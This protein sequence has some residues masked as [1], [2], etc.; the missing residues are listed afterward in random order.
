MRISP[1]HLF[2][3]GPHRLSLFLALGLLMSSMP[4]GGAASAASSTESKREAS[5]LLGML[6]MKFLPLP[7]AT[8]TQ[9]AFSISPSSGVQGKEYEVIVSSKDDCL[10]NPLKTFKLY[11]PIGSGIVVNS[12]Q[13]DCQLTAKLTIAP[14][15]PLGPVKLWLTKDAGQ[16]NTPTVEFTV[17][18][19]TPQPIP[20]GL[21]NKGT[22][23]VMWSVLPDAVTNDNFGGKVSREFYCIEAVIGNDSGYDLQLSSIGFTLPGLA[24]GKY[25]IPSSGYRTV[26]GSLEAFQT[27]APRQFVVN[28]FK[29]LG[30]LLTGFLPFFHAVNHKSNF[31]QAI[32]V[33]SNPLEKG[34]ESIWPDLVPTELDRLAD[35][36]FRDDVS[37]KTIIPNN[38]QARIL[39]FVPRRLVCP[40]KKTCSAANSTPTLSAKNPQHVMQALGEIVIVGQ[41][42][43]HVNRVRV[44]NTP[45]G[46][47]VTDHSISGKITDACNEGVGDVTVSLSAGGGFLDRTVTTAKDGTYEFANIPDGRT[48]T[49]KPELGDMKFLPAISESFLLN[50]TKTNLDFSAGHLIVGTAK[51]G[52]TPLKQYSIELTQ[53]VATAKKTMTTSTN[54]KG[55]YRFQLPGAATP[56]FTIKPVDLKDHTFKPVKVDW[57]CGMGPVDFVATPTPSPSPAASAPQ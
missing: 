22:V 17:T 38:V 30:P 27:L 47:S 16:L 4:T 6:P 56:P 7:D 50:D 15:A 54:D 41:E 28:G 35:M 49:V 14:D 36:T 53:I 12:K 48:Y 26:R 8:P 55:E 18:G 25:R 51:K 2:Q 13:G 57:N 23:D 9:P 45:F 21:N 32:N 24:A 3:R 11:A 34:L 42:I 40:D 52:E 43:V 1:S 33:I 46:T 10:A 5:C 44:V 39:T 37:T 29:M 19:V 31:S 20:P